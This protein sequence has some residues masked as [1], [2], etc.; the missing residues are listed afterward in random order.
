ME[1][2]NIVT[3]QFKFTRDKALILI[4]L[5]FL[6]WHPRPLNSE[7]LTLTTY[8]PAPYGGYVSLLTTGKTLLARDGGNVGIGL[9]AAAPGVKLD[10]KGVGGGSVDVRVNGRFQTGDASG[11]GGMWLSSANDGFVGNNA[12]NIGF[13]TTGASWNAFQIVKANG[14]VGIGTASPTRE[15]DVEG[16][17]RIGSSGVAGTGGIYGLCHTQP[18]GNGISTCTG[19]TIVTAIYGNECPTGGLVLRANSTDIHLASNW[20]PHMA[21][22]CN[23][24]MLCCRIFPNAN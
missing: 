3:I 5:F 2:E 8:Y 20:I 24:T 16:N 6:C 22:N 19:G 23:G 21:Q 17:L 1:N 18:F 15:L 10:V 9:G 12:G 7:T 4:A 11:N 13:W 14:Y